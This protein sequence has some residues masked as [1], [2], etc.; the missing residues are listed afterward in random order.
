MKNINKKNVT[1]NKIKCS[2]C[3]FL[4]K[5]SSNSQKTCSESC[6][7]TRTNRLTQ[8]RKYNLTCKECNKNFV[9]KYSDRKFCSKKCNIANKNKPNTSCKNCGKKFHAKPSQLK[10]IKEPSCSKECSNEI[11]KIKGWENYLSLNDICVVCGKDKSIK[12]SYSNTKKNKTCSK[13]CKYIYQTT[14]HEYYEKALYK[15]KDKNYQELHR[16]IQ[17]KIR[18]IKRRAKN[19]NLKFD[20][21]VF[22]LISIIPTNRMCPVFNTPMI[23]KAQNNKDLSASVDRIDN[24]KG[25]TKDNVCWISYKA[26]RLKNEMNIDDI[27]LIYEFMKFCDIEKKFPEMFGSMFIGKPFNISI[28]AKNV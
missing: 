9:N 7:K 17:N 3:C 19:K 6:K 12:F 25:Y 1:K 15:F 26:N 20:L 11:R 27:K 22:W 24:K 2:E 23:Y 8:P 4:F 18:S 5:P 13:E 28:S 10:R 16:Y 14:K 21:D